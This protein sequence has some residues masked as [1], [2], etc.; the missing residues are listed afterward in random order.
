MAKNRAWKEEKKKRVKRWR[1]E[2]ISVSWWPILLQNYN[3]QFWHKWRHLL[4]CYFLQQQ[5]SFLAIKI[6]WKE[7][8]NENEKNLFRRADGQ[9]FCEGRG[10][11][12]EG[13]HVSATTV[14][15]VCCTQVSRNSW[16]RLDIYRGST[17][18]PP[19]S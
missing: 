9:F 6:A 19:K 15:A 8:K 13:S 10:P 16:S 14:S 3:G 12:E 7:E 18:L 5:E 4:Y 17:I 1:K 2:P 11:L